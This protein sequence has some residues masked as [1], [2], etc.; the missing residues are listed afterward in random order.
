MSI[1][2]F[3]GLTVV[4]ML[5]LS[6]QSNVYQISGFAY[7]FMDGD[8]IC[9]RFESDGKRPVYITMGISHFLVRRV[10]LLY[11]TSILRT[12]Q[13][14]RYH[15]FLNQPRSPWSYHYYQRE[16]E[17]PAPLSTIHGKN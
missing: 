8:T 12:D 11:V 14:V 17:Y 16:T 7:G 6:C 15:S 4:G 3:L 13:R 1:K 9:L 2:T 10:P 5:C